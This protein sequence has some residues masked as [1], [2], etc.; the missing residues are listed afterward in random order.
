M[1]AQAS[2]P[3]AQRPDVEDTSVSRHG[4]RLVPPSASAGYAGVAWAHAKAQQGQGCPEDKSP[5]GQ[6]APESEALDLHQKHHEQ[7]PIRP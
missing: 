4:G 3:N 5:S 2:R 6:G 7:Q 1:R